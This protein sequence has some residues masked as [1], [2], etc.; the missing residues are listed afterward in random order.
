MEIEIGKLYDYFDDGKISE[1]RRQD[2]LITEKVCFKDIDSETREQWEDEVKTCHWLYAP[3]TDYFLKGILDP[4]ED[5]EPVVFVR[6]L[7]G[8]WFSLGFW[9]GRLKDKSFWKSIKDE[10]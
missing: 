4:E 3:K 5:K 6:T 2:V 1:S 10:S 8:G 9:A 7:D